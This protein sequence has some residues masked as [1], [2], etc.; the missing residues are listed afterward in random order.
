MESQP[1]RTLVSFVVCGIAAE[2][3]SVFQRYYRLIT[4]AESRHML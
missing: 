2:T 4:P 3:G 1:L